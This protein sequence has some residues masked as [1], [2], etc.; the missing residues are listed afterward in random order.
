[1]VSSSGLRRC[2]PEASLMFDFGFFIFG[3]VIFYYFLFDCMLWSIFG[4]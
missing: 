3:E 1:M 4:R 2:L